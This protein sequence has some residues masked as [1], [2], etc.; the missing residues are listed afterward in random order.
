MGINLGPKGYDEL[1][2]VKSSHFLI[3]S[4]FDEKISAAGCILEENMR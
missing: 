3:D 4:L 2:K 1:A